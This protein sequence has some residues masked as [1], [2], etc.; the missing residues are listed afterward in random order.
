MHIHMCDPA[1]PL[2]EFFSASCRVLNLLD[3][4]KSF[5]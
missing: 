1:E 5:I 2:P 3:R 4:F